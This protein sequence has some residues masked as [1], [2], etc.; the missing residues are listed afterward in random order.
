MY[1]VFPK[2]LHYFVSAGCDPLADKNKHASLQKKSI[3]EDVM[4]S[5]PPCSELQNSFPTILPAKETQPS[6]LYKQPQSDNIHI[7][8]SNPSHLTVQGHSEASQSQLL[9]A[10]Q[11]CFDNPGTSSNL[12][13]SRLN[14]SA[15]AIENPTGSKTQPWPSPETL[16]FPPP[17]QTFPLVSRGQF[18][19][20][21]CKQDYGYAW[22]PSANATFPPDYDPRL[23]AAPS[24]GESGSFSIPQ[25][26]ETQISGPG[27]RMLPVVVM[28]TKPLAIDS[29]EMTKV[30]IKHCSEKMEGEKSNRLV[31]KPYAFKGPPPRLVP[32]QAIV[33]QT[34][35]SPLHKEASIKTKVSFEDS[36][37][38]QKIRREAFRLGP[39]QD[40]PLPPSKEEQE[41]LLGQ[42]PLV[43][44]K[45]EASVNTTVKDIRKR[46]SKVFN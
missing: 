11:M 1:I 32:R 19:P 18:P 24:V 21:V 27:Q 41:I 40:V 35:H 7:H 38:N 12:P 20:V 26:S 5:L 34:S 39:V 10:S 8:Q 9:H 44:P 15:S 42:R 17:Y 43:E 28:S 36:E 14:I 33:K 31:I 29:A 25:A 2:L 6:V 13:S 22:V 4:D 46:L 3:T 45:V 37:V 16:M 23:I 30:A